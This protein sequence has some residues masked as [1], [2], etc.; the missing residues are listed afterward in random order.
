MPYFSFLR[1][2]VTGAIVVLSVACGDVA[3]LP[4]QADTGPTPTIAAPN[5]TRVPT[6]NIAPAKGW[7]ADA[8]PSAAP[9]LA[10]NAFF[11]NDAAPT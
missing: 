2:A 6:V 11:F 7:P 4:H 5:P 1:V 8:T 9:G 10:V 3:K